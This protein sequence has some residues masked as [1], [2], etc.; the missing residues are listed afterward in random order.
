MRFIHKIAALTVTLFLT[1]P[2]LYGAVRNDVVVIEASEGIQNAVEH[3]TTDY[4]L[5]YLYPAKPSLRKEALKSVEFLDQNIKKI[6]INSND[7]RTKGILRY[8]AT[9]RARILEILQAPPNLQ[10]IGDL[11]DISRVFIEGAR[12][13]AA[14]H[15]YPFSDEEKMLMKTRSMATL[16]RSVLK[17][18]LATKILP[19]D[20]EN[21]KYFRRTLKEF[22]QD[23]AD[24]QKYPYEGEAFTQRKALVRSWEAETW[25]M[26]HLPGEGAPILLSLG[27]EKIAGLLLELSIYH[28]KK[29]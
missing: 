24:L 27:D 19:D 11:I 20:K 8:F 9:Q 12:S 28:S 1:A 15:S 26:N 5:Y 13:I 25:Y 17:Y 21:L 18:Y 7:A 22:D 10:N 6:V 23:L 2:A 3:L 29:R 4:L 14:H 16:S